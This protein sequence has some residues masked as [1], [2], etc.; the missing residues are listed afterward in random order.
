VS[1]PI[2]TDNVITLLILPE[3][4]VNQAT[5]PLTTSFSYNSRDTTN[6]L[7][8]HQLPPLLR[9]VMVAIDET[10][11]QIL[12][13][14]NGTNPPQLISATLFQTA[15]EQQLSA[16]LATLDASLTAQKIGH[17]IFQRDLLLPAANWSN[18]A[19]Q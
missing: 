13:T 18:T 1:F 7:T 6:K 16:D 3:N 12:A 4:V 9:I 11:A 14:Q 17:R 8:L 15:T 2:L 5:S 19:S 10:S